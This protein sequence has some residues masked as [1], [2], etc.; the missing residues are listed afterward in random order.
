MLPPLPV[1]P[2]RGRAPRG[3]GRGQR[4]RA[5]A[6]STAALHCVPAQPVRGDAHRTPRPPGT[7][8]PPLALT[9]TLTPGTKA[10]PPPPYPRQNSGRRTSP[11]TFLFPRRTQTSLFHTSLLVAF[12]EI[13]V[14]VEGSL[15]NQL[16]HTKTEG[17]GSGQLGPE[18]ICFCGFILAL[19]PGL[20]D[21]GSQTRD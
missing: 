3:A 5:A 14:L 19:L 6:G 4:P 21:L 18:V 15:R 17:T 7:P 12:P 2:A 13:C 11:G 8:S 1:G 20:R 9:L 10:R 16:S